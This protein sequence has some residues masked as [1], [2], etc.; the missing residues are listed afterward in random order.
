MEKVIEIYPLSALLPSPLLPTREKVSAWG[1]TDEGAHLRN[2][3]H[4]YIRAKNQRGRR[5]PSSVSFAA[6]FSREGRR[7]TE[8]ADPIA[9]TPTSSLVF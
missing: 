3:R 1:P 5:T 7:I 6:T 2:H 9:A 4:P 8:A